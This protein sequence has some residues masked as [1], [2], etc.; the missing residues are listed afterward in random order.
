MSTDVSE[1]VSVKRVVRRDKDPVRVSSDGRVSYYTGG[2]VGVGERKQ[3]RCGSR[4]AAEVEAERLRAK[5]AK[6]HGAQP[7]VF[8]TLDQAFQAM[9]IARRREGDTSTIDQ[10][11]SNWNCW[12]PVSIGSTLC[13]DVSIQQWAAIFDHAVAKGASVSTVRNVARTL[14]A[15]M[16]WADDRGYFLE[17]EA[18][19]EPRRR[20]RIVKNAKKACPPP[21][22]SSD[23]ISM[24]LCPTTSDVRRFARAFEEQYPGYGSRLVMLAFGSG[25]RINEL[26]A[27][28]HD[29]IDLETGEIDVL[30]QLDR[31]RPWPATKL[32]KNKRT[33]TAVMWSAVRD[34]AASLVED[35]LALPADDPHHGWLFPRHRS[36]TAWATQCGRLATAAATECEW[37]WT[38]HWLRHAYASYSL[39][40]TS[41][42]GFGLSPKSVS[43]WLGH[44]RPSITLDMYVARQAGDVEHSRLQTQIL[45]AD[46][47]A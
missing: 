1:N 4:A 44:K 22:T 23:H 42:N 45:P 39:A 16:S 5:F 41:S 18:F 7:G 3:K 25:L 15:F 37:E 34:V 21:K 20:Q 31:S 47:A 43:K 9:V 40:P 2:A 24:D 38:F 14:N 35:S 11:R 33:R 29:S 46:S 17:A 6:M 10:Y 30:V 32:P 13:A 26:L 19:G 27:L 28:R 36:V 12:V 8:C